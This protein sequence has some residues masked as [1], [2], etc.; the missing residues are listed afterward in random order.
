MQDKSTVMTILK[1]LRVPVNTKGYRYLLT[2]I[3][4]CVEDV[5]LL[6]K[7]TTR[8]YPAIA[9]GDENN[10]ACVERL[11]RYAIQKAFDECDKELWKEYFGI[12]RK[13]KVSEFVAAIVLQLQ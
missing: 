11:M 12:S 4:M 6:S 2:A 9:E 13:T 5:R 10:A 1:N 7:M 8:L 3:L